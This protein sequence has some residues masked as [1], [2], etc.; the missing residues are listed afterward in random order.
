MFERNYGC[1]SLEE[2]L[3]LQKAKVAVC[4]IG[5]GGCLCSEILVRTGI[6]HIT[7]IDGDKFDDSNKNRQLGALDS[8]LNQYKVDVI[9]NRLKDI[10]KNVIIKSYSEYIN[11]N[12]FKEYLKNIDIV[13]DCVDGKDNKLLINN[14]CEILKLPFVTGGLNGYNLCSAIVT[15]Y[16][17]QRNRFK[18]TFNKSISA[19]PSSL[20]IQA[21]LQSQQIINFIL[22][23]N[24]FDENK[25]IFMNH[26]NYSLIVSDVL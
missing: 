3:L 23:R 20:F 21:G 5:G 9:K 18:D 14:F 10:N 1:Y 2:M 7:L 13:C 17:F 12:N 4:G 15:D 26:N 8:T 6:G 24:W 11:F 25:M 19:N 22:K 16:E